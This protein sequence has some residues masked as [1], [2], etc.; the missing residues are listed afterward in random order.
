MLGSDKNSCFC[1]FGDKSLA[2]VHKY[3]YL[4]V[5]LFSIM[6]CNQDYLTKEE[7]NR[8]VLDEG[9]GLIKKETVKGYQIQVTYRPTDLLILQE[10]GGNTSANPHEL[11]RLIQK[12]KDYRYF[13]LSFSK[14]NKEAL[15]N[16]GD[17]YGQNAELIQVLSF[18]MGSYVNITTSN[19]DTVFVAD[20]IY[21][22]T[23]G[24]NYATNL[25]FVFSKDKI[26]ENE[27]LQFNLKEFGLHLGNQ[28]FRF[29][30]RDLEK[31]PKIKFE[32]LH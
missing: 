26:K 5:V 22:R 9:N 17:S 1:K 7:L 19:H 20:Y 10:L 11:E 25:M 29:S 24:M 28:K 30:V 13:I 2:A 21:P 14:D 16:S 12:Y 4:I 8:Y 18:R 3:F 27:W 6:S 31:T 15:N 23:F 32:S